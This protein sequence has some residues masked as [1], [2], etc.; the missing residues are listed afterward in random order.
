MPINVTL[1]ADSNLKGNVKYRTGG[2]TRA[3]VIET[4]EAVSNGSIANKNIFA[5][6]SIE[7]SIPIERC[8]LASHIGLVM[9]TTV[10][11][12]EIT[13]LDYINDNNTSVQ[14]AV[15]YFTSAQMTESMRPGFFTGAQ[16]LC[17]RTNLTYPKESVVNQQPEPYQGNDY[18]E[19]HSELSTQICNEFNT[20]IG[21][22]PNYTGSDLITKGY[23]YVLWISSFAAMACEL[24]GS[25]FGATASGWKK[26]PTA[27][28]PGI[29]IRPDFS[30]DYNAN[31]HWYGAVST[32]FP[33]VFDSGAAHANMSRFID[34]MLSNVGIQVNL[35]AEG[36]VDDGNM[37]RYVTLDNGQFFY[38][39]PQDTEEFVTPM[40]MVRLI[41]D[42]DI[43]RVQ[44]IPQSMC[45][46]GAPDLLYNT[47]NIDTGYGLNNFNP[48]IDERDYV[49]PDGTVIQ[50][51]SKSKLMHY[52]Y[53]YFQLETA[54]GN[55]M[56]I[57]PQLHMEVNNYLNEFNI[58]FWT[59]KIGGDRACCQITIVDAEQ[60]AAGITPTMDGFTGKWYTVYEFPTINWATDV[61]SAEQLA[62]IQAV[63]S[64]KAMQHNAI[65]GA[66]TK[67]TGFQYGLRG[68]QANAQQQGVLRA[69][70]TR[71]GNFMNHGF[72]GEP[73]PTAVDVL[74]G[75]SNRMYNE[76]AQQIQEGEAG[77][78]IQTENAISVGG[79][80]FT[81]LYI[82]PLSLFRGGMTYGE[83]F[84]FG[85]FIDREGQ[86]C[87][88]NI[89]P[90]TNAGNIFGGNA[91]ITSYGG[92]TY[93]KFYNLDVFGTMPVDFKS[94]IQLMFCAGCYLI[95]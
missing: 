48:L 49:L 2:L 45:W 79:D 94:A 78:I 9:G 35:P 95:T 22:N 74:G 67:G 5:D 71:F 68:G 31:N 40:T 87:H 65:V 61:S 53:W 57:M 33:I 19:S 72:G 62:S 52:P 75:G 25:D 39:E 64:Q 70:V 1:Y 8:A 21:L 38:P 47:F 41:S 20:A 93:Y 73:D 32:G 3:T 46:N 63:A 28:T 6:N 34:A 14:Y 18:K 60:R 55:T 15:D 77:R 37:Y 36:I 80:T 83:L 90:L 11:A 88:L 26:N 81:N 69:A 42:K 92:K 76:L 56:T 17:E 54:A 27:P 13:G 91:S 10:I 89:N 29:A 16:G 86:T 7:I 50:D 43:Y 44:I 24:N 51:F 82:K 84:G 12:G 66:S 85:R 30:S 4:L 59:K 58:E 23:A